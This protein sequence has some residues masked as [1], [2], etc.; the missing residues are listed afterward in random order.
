MATG[1]RHQTIRFDAPVTV[2]SFHPKS[3]KLFIAT[4]QTHETYLVDLREGTYGR[5][6]LMETIAPGGNTN[7]SANGQTPVD[8]KPSTKKLS[9]TTA[10][11]SADGKTIHAGTS[12][13][14]LYTFSTRT[15]EMLSCTRITTGPSAIKHL[16]FDRSGRY[17][18]VNSNDRIIR[19]LEMT[20]AQYDF[21]LLHQFSDPINRTPWNGICFSSDGE[22][23]VAGAGS[24]MGHTIYIWDR[25]T[26]ALVKMLEGPTEPLV[27][28]DWHPFRPILTS[29][30]I[31]GLV[32]IWTTTYRENWSA[33]APGFEEL[34]E[35]VEYE[36]RE[37]E[38][39]IEDESVLLRRK[40]LE[41]ELEVDVESFEPL[42]AKNADD[43]QTLGDG[44]DEDDLWVQQEPDEDVVPDFAP[45][46]DM[47]TDSEDE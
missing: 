42:T 14:L 24:K 40:A 41:E 19:V 37:D 39:D 9:T 6:E 34:D 16:A 43:T 31:S 36:E 15:K 25:S 8:L 32:H 29:V 20:N 10:C 11:F 35:N 46:V 22:Y 45:V 12:Q 17:L 4:L 44:P 3:S 33:F 26:G 5:T 2:A 7:S 1:Q 18:I 28:A 27:D 23:V 30:A 21:E 13:G 38:F 47:E